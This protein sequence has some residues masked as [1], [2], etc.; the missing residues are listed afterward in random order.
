[1]K[2]SKRI[3]TTKDQSN[4]LPLPVIN[5]LKKLRRQKVEAVM[6]SKHAGSS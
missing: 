4:D 1:M 6:R 5:T 2:G 3:V